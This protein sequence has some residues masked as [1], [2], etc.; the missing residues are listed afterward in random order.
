MRA[1]WLGLALCACGDNTDQPRLVALTT[2]PAG[3]EDVAFDNTDVPVVRNESGAL[4]RFVDKRWRA[5][6]MMDAHAT[7]FGSDSDGTLLVMSTVPRR[8]YQLGSNGAMREVGPIVLANY[9]HMPMQAPSGNRYVKEIEGEQRSFVLSPGSAMWVESPPLFFSRPVRAY[10]K[11]LYAAA[12]GGV[13][14]FAPDGTRPFAVTCAQL[15]KTSCTGLLVGG[16]DGERVVV[17]DID[18]PE[19]IVVDGETIE[20]VPLNTVVPVRIAVG[21]GMTVVLAKHAAATPASETYALF[22]IDAEG[23][24]IS[25]EA[26]SDPPSSATRL[27]VDHAGTVHVMTKSLSTVVR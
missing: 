25:L 23:A 18:D 13:Q 26:K 4:Q 5:V 1:L 2:V 17:A 10:D 11:T 6:A 14:R 24:L 27:A 21:K 8:L 22:A 19:V 3:T 20:R 9:V 16:A 15:G 12:P 7:D